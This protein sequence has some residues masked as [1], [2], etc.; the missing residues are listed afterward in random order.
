MGEEVV[1]IASTSSTTA[2]DN[3]PVRENNATIY[4][5]MLND[6][7]DTNFTS[8]EIVGDFFKELHDDGSSKSGINNIVDE[9]YKDSH[10]QRPSSFDGNGNHSKNAGYFNEGCKFKCGLFNKDD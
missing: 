5:M 3:T 1:L 7:D 4:E 8:D 9:F 6:A 2:M 10:E